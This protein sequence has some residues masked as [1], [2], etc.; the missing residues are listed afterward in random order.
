MSGL[1]C[2]PSTPFSTNCFKGA[3]PTDPGGPTAPRL[4]TDFADPKGNPAS[5]FEPGMA[6]QTTDRQTGAAPHFRPR[7]VQ[8]PGQH[9][10]SNRPRMRC[11]RQPNERMSC[12]VDDHCRD[13]GVHHNWRRVRGRCWHSG[14][15]HIRD[16]RSRSRLR[17]VSLPLQNPWHR[18][19]RKA[20][21]RAIWEMAWPPKRLLFPKDQA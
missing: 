5:P 18:A 7:H 2:T 10:V 16:G 4:M 9:Q 8:H 15:D 6:W 11:L 13:T 20:D 1:G 17:R 21:L 19:I 12:S 14:N 3:T